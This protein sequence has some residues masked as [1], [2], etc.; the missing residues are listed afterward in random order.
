MITDE[1]NNSNSEG[2]SRWT[3]ATPQQAQAATSRGD[4]APLSRAVE[5]YAATGIQWA[6]VSSTSRCTDMQIVFPR[7]H[8]EYQIQCEPRNAEKVRGTRTKREKTHHHDYIQ[9]LSELTL[10]LRSV[11]EDKNI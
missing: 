2:Y 11:E 1:K 6:D 10:H 9:M 8:Q 3:K 7:A 4:T 5:G